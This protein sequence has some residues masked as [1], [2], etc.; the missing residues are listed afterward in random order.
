[1]KKQLKMKT[2]ARS[3][4]NETGPAKNIA[5]QILNQPDSLKSLMLVFS[6]L[7]PGLVRLF[8]NLTKGACQKE[9]WAEAELASAV[10]PGR[11]YPGDLLI[12]KN[13]EPKIGDILHIALK[14]SEDGSYADDYVVAKKTSI[15]NR[16]IFVQD[17]DDRKHTGKIGPTNIMYSISEVVKFGTPKWDLLKDSL[18]I[19]INKTHLIGNLNKYIKKI[20]SNSPRY[21][22][23]YLMELRTRLRE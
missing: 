20:E 15:K 21:K 6:Q 4:E 3:K 8:V 12:K 9:E 13:G 17:I 10:Y 23:E 7:D 16:S 19:D 11:Y 1:M 2:K 14:D 18:K 5:A 22:R